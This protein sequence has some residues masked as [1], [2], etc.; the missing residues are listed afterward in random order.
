M[1][2]KTG[3]QASRTTVL[4]SIAVTVAASVAALGGCA[5]YDEQLV[6]ASGREGRCEM[7]GVGGIGMR[8][9]REG[10]AVC[11]ETLNALGFIDR[12]RVGDLGIETI[13]P[14]AGYLSIDRVTPASSAASHGVEAGDALLSINGRRVN[15]VVDARRGLF[16]RA[17]D[18][19]RVEVMQG[20]LTRTVVLERETAEQIAAQ[21]QPFVAPGAGTGL[22]GAALAT[23]DG[24]A[25][26]GGGSN[27]GG[28]APVA[29]PA[30]AS[31]TVSATGAGT[32]L[33][34][35]SSTPLVIPGDP[36]N[37]R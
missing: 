35:A 9:A 13:R 11:R 7:T 15:H 19:A 34:P 21:G 33:T 10:V 1:T 26:A 36:A 2:A 28:A 29:G 14:D 22:P 31:G 5:S 30:E 20:D 8:Q 27:A 12:D 3:K 4:A 23:P 32:G 24:S 16:G 18:S 37:S 17:G 6:D 25:G